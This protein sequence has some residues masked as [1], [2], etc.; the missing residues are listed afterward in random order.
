[1]RVDAILTIIIEDEFESHTL[2]SRMIALHCK[3]LKLCGVFNSV[4][5]ASYYIKRNKVDLIFLDIEL[6]NESGFS[7]FEYFPSPKFYVILRRHIIIMQLKL[8]N[9]LQLIIS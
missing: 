9:F 1:M 7:L 5:E 4:K 2:L 6:P 8:L 3:N